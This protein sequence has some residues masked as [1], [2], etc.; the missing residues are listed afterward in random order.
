MIF[1]FVFT[2]IGVV[3]LQYFA[4][5]FSIQG[6]NRAILFT[7]IELMYKSVV[8]YGDTPHFIRDDF[9]GLV[10]SY[11]EKTL[12]RYTKN[13]EVE[14][15]YYNLNDQSMCLIDTCDGVEITIDCKLNATYN[16][17]RVMFYEMRESNN[18]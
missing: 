6:L 7:P 2:L 14:F 1:M 11:Y 12:P 4:L 10:L 17:H 3:S 5:N 9:E 15:Y 8:A 13:Y 16:Y 18:G